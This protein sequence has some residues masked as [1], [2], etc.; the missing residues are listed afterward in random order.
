MGSIIGNIAYG[1]SPSQ[2]DFRVFETQ[3]ALNTY[4]SSARA[5]AGQT[6]K[7][8]D[9]ATGKYKAYIIQGTAG[10]FTTVQMGGSYVVASSL[11]E[12][13]NADEDT[14]YYIGTSATGYVHYRLIGG[15]FRAVGGDTSGI[16]D[17]ISDI[18]TA[19]AGKGVAL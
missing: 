16:E 19:L 6:V 18:N 2:E 7:L 11:P 4:L 17:A 15:D 8:K 14:D 5:K 1:A 3:S 13:S 12:V 10:N 9:T